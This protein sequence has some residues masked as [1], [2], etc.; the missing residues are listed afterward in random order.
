[1]GEEFG[2][3]LSVSEF[4]GPIDYIIPVPLHP[5]RLRSRGYNQAEI[6]AE[7]L[8]QSLG[9]P[10]DTRLLLRNVDTQTQTRKTRADRIRNV[11]GAFT[12]CNGENYKGCSFLLV[13][14][15]VTT[16]ATLEECGNTLLAIPGITLN[17]A[18]LAFAYGL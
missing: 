15:V 9:V 6:I 13:D 5:R 1:M 16:G 10:V 18:T 2:R 17:I 14:D 12:L 7:G 11:S 4:F 3:V 8:S